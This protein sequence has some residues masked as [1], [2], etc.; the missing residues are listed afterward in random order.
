MDY[1]DIAG[2]RRTVPDGVVENYVAKIKQVYEMLESID[3]SAPKKEFIQ[4]MA[5]SLRIYASIMRSCG[6]FAEAQAHQGQERCKTKW[7]NTQAR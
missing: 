2:A 3:A 6:N 1:S 7:P 4:N 5:T